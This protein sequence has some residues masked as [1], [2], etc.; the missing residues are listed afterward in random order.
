MDNIEIR[1]TATNAKYLNRYIE[2]ENYTEL[3]ITNDEDYDI[4]IKIDKEDSV[5]LQNYFW[6]SSMV[7]REGY[8]TPSFYCY[9]NKKHVLL[10]RIILSVETGEKV[11]FLDGDNTNYRRNNLHIVKKKQSFIRNNPDKELPT[12]IFKKA[13][14]EKGN[15]TGYLVCYFEKNKK[16]TKYFG[17]RKYKELSTALEKAIEFKEKMLKKEG[18][19][20]I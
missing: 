4:V 9:I 10:S 20:I 13:Q 3:H 12:G 6:C 8:Q 5:K 18:I 1:S 7:G 11:I 15:I 14:K 16:K 19:N 17:I 2:K